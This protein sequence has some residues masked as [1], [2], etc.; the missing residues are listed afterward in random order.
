LSCSDSPALAGGFGCGMITTPNTGDQPVQVY[1]YVSTQLE[2]SA[3]SYGN[4]VGW[5]ILIIVVI[6][7]ATAMGFKWISHLKR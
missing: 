5:M 7:I 6:K 4:Q 3:E 1:E 2:N